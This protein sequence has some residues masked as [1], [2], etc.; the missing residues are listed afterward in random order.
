MAEASC[1]EI[2]GVSYASDPWALRRTFSLKL[3]VENRVTSAMP[4][5]Q[6]TAEN[7]FRT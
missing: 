3:E 4:T 6:S 5:T 1:L 7:R 2:A